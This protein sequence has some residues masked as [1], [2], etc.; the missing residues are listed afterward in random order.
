MFLSKEVHKV[1]IRLFYANLFCLVT[2]EGEEVILK[3]FDQG[4]P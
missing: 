4:V 1:A 2:F 3:S